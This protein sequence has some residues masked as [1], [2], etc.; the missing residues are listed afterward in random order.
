MKN[1]NIIPKTVEQAEEVKAFLNIIDAYYLVS[2]DE[3][4]A[5]SKLQNDEYHKAHNKACIDMVNQ[6]NELKKS[7]E[8]YLKLNMLDL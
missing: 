8:I 3:S 4:R 6:V 5:Q 7:I 2:T 1:I